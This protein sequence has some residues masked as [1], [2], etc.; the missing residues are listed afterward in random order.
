MGPTNS[1]SHFFK[2]MYLNLNKEVSSRMLMGALQ[3][4]I[5]QEEQPRIRFYMQ[6]CGGQP[7]IGIQKHIAKHVMYVGEQVGHREGM[8]CL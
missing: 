1:I 2:A 6:G 5:V 7:F 4:D 3:E 8:R